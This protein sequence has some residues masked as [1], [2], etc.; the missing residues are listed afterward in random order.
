MSPP[1][2]IRLATNLVISGDL[3]IRS[4]PPVFLSINVDNKV[5]F[6]FFISLLILSA[7]ARA[8]T[9]PHTPADAQL[10]PPP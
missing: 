6:Y 9:H 2:P 8:H 5:F 3:S 10:S 7:E 4:R 1:P